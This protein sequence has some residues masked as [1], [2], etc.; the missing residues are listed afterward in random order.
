[1]EVAQ[2]MEAAAP[3]AQRINKKIP[4]IRF[5]L[6][7]KVRDRKDGCGAPMITKG[8]PAIKT[9]FPRNPRGIGDWEG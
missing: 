1:M 7:S 2:A 8:V 5:M 4:E 9:D 3:A 6:D